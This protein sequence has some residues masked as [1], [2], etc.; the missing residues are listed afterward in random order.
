MDSLTSSLNKMDLKDDNQK[1]KMSKLAS[2]YI[3]LLETRGRDLLP[4][5]SMKRSAK[6]KGG[7]T[8]TNR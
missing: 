5:K 2:D 8:K 6:K 7:N 4:K 3:K 1:S